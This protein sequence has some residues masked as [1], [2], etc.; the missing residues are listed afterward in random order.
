[1]ES[2]DKLSGCKGS[3]RA[4]IAAIDLSYISYRHIRLVTSLTI[5]RAA[6]A[7]ATSHKKPGGADY[8]GGRAARR[9]TWVVTE[10]AGSAMRLLFTAIDRSRR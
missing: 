10:V 5:A 3:N 7:H 4:P 2:N 8:G 1:M 9:N 6:C